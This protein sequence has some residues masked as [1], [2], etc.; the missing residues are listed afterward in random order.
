MKTNIIMLE[1]S[2]AG[3]HERN[4]H[5]HY[6]KIINHQ[7]IPGILFTTGFMAISMTDDESAM[8]IR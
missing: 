7:C 4:E 6:S 3:R 2:L 1:L 5:K 8:A